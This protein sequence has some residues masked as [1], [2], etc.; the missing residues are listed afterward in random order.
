M[1]SNFVVQSGDSLDGVEIGFAAYSVRIENF[2]NQWLI[3]GST[4]A[5]IPPYTVARV[6]QLGG[7]QVGRL[8]NRSPSSVFGQPPIVAGEFTEVTYHS[9]SQPDVAGLAI[10]TPPTT[11]SDQSLFNAPA[12]GVI[13]DLTEAV[14]GNE[15]I[16]V[17]G[18][19]ADMV[20][21]GTNPTLSGLQILNGVTTIWTQYM[22]VSAT[23]GDKD[24]IATRLNLSLDIGAGLTVRFTSTNPNVLQ[25]IST[26]FR[27]VTP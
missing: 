23:T 10:A 11:G 5:W 19:S 13:A 25:S 8:D 2:S 20:Q 3:E 7:T 24:H 27:V 9:D 12:A 4:Q 16:V 14:A 22:G 17:T 26:T 18:I 6:I 15:L 1:D 21:G